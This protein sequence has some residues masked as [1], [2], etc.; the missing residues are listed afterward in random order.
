MIFGVDL[1][2]GEVV[3]FDG[4]RFTVD[5]WYDALGEQCEADR[6]RACVFQGWGGVWIAVDLG[7]V[8]TPEVL[9]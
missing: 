2:A 4:S 9:H 1:G 7:K 5:A 6:A 8:H 3:C